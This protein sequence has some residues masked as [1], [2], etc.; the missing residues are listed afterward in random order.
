M[1]QDFTSVLLCCVFSFKR[2]F[3]PIAGKIQCYQRFGHFEY[4]LLL[5]QHRS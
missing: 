4:N 2:E 3:M 1:Y 5:K